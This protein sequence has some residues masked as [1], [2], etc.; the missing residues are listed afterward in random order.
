MNIQFSRLTK[1]SRAFTEGREA[2]MQAHQEIATELITPTQLD[3]DNEVRGSRHPDYAGCTDYEAAEHIARC[4]GI[5]VYGD[6]YRVDLRTCSARTFRLLWILRQLADAS[7][8]SYGTYVDLA[9]KCLYGDGKKRLEL[10]KL[11]TPAMMLR[12]MARYDL[13]V[14]QGYEKESVPPAAATS[15]EVAST[16]D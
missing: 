6:Q 5:N 8:I 9:L 3:F 4:I 11:A 10:A 16:E 1:L 12:V 2:L 15:T 7:G 13:E 14:R